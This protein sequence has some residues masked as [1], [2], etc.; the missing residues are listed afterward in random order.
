[1]SALLEHETAALRRIAEKSH[2]CQDAFGPAYPEDVFALRAQYFDYTIRRI[3]AGLELEIDTYSAFV[4]PLLAPLCA[5]F[6]EEK[7]EALLIVFASSQATRQAY[8]ELRRIA[9]SVLSGASVRLSDGKVRNF[10][11]EALACTPT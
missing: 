11:G 10:M 1:M 5:D 3:D 4:E 8:L 7:A 9:R 2:G 6:D